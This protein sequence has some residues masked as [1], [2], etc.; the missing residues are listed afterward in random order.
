LLHGSN[1]KYD[2]L[3]LIDMVSQMCLALSGKDKDKMKKAQ[4]LD[5]QSIVGLHAINAAHR[6]L[7]PQNFLIGRK[8]ALPKKFG[9]Y[10]FFPFQLL[11]CDFGV[12]YV[13]SNVHATSKF[14]IQFGLSY[15]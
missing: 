5:Y 7:K 13:E 9:N 10:S 11:L 14:S 15:P 3:D 1:F 12:S 4:T 2:S 6:A 8:P